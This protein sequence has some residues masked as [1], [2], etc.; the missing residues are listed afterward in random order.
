LSFDWFGEADDGSMIRN[1]SQRSLL[2]MNPSGD[3]LPAAAA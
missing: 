3:G 1:P 2:V